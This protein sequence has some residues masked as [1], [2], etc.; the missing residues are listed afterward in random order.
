MSEQLELLEIETGVSREQI[1]PDIIEPTVEE[2]KYYISLGDDF[3]E[4][5]IQYN[6]T[7]EKIQRAY[8]SL[9]SEKDFSWYQG[10]LHDPTGKTFPTKT[11][12]G[13]SLSTNDIPR[14][15]AYFDRLLGLEQ[16]KVRIGEERE[17]VCNHIS[18][19]LKEQKAQDIIY[20][21]VD[22]LEE[23]KEENERLKKE[24][25]AAKKKHIEDE[26]RFKK[27]QELA[28][29]KKEE[30]ERLEKEESDRKIREEANRVKA[31]EI[32]LRLEEEIRKRDEEIE[33]KRA[34]EEKLRAEEA[35]NILKEEDEEIDTAI[36]SSSG[37]EQGSD[38]TSVL[39]VPRDDSVATGGADNPTGQ[40]LVKSPYTTDLE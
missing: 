34:Q 31:E 19:K 29:G 17:K 3:S 4:A 12:D 37:S 13:F 20:K 32:K 7:L 30:Q 16:E 11:S 27:E 40:L 14:S 36:N 39:E 38:Q 5:K 28:Q 24:A 15:Q 21:Q 26:K 33:R 2:R 22:Y 10:L 25:R 35:K 6:T 9:S 1:T 18:R 23:V 8:N